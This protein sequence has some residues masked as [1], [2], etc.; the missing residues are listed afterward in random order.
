M[1]MPPSKTASR[2]STSIPRQCSSGRIHV[3][4]SLYAILVFAVVNQW[5]ERTGLPAMWLNLRRAS[6]RT[7]HV[8]RDIR[9]FL[10][11]WTTNLPKSSLST[12]PASPRPP[13]ILHAPFPLSSAEARSHLAVALVVTCPASSTSTQRAIPLRRIRRSCGLSY[14]RALP[15]VQK[16]LA[17][18]SS[19]SIHRRLS[20]LLLRRRP[21]GSTKN[22]WAILA[23]CPYGG[24]IYGGGAAI[25]ATLWVANSSEMDALAFPTT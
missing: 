16:R 24:T 2:R 8:S 17:N 6:A 13:S 3:P 1:E 20:Y 4:S 19:A 11:D 12:H 18:P 9:K 7:E 5:T 14:H 23:L 21:W 15:L 10:A 25:V 22:R